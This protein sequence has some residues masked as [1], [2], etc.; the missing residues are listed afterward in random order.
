MTRFAL[1]MTTAEKTTFTGDVGYATTLH[2][3]EVATSAT[4]SIQCECLHMFVYLQN[5]LVM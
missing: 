3:T 1:F 2:P 5:L 4:A